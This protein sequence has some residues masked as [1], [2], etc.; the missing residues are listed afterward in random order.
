MFEK[1]KRDAIRLEKLNPLWAI[2]GIG[3]LIL[4]IVMAFGAW[5]WATGTNAHLINVPGKMLVTIPRPDT[6]AGDILCI[7]NADGSGLKQ[8]D[9]GLSQH[10]FAA[11]SPNGDQIA[12]TGLKDNATFPR[13][14]IMNADSSNVHRLTEDTALNVENAP[15]WSPDAR[16]IAYENYDVKTS[17]YTIRTIQNDGSNP[18][19]LVPGKHPVWSPDGQWIAYK[20]IQNGTELYVMKPDGSGAHP[21][22]NAP[23]KEDITWSPDSK[24]LAFIMVE[25][26]G[27][28]SIATVHLDGTNLRQLIK[29]SG[30]LSKPHWSPDGLRIAF[31]WDQDAQHYSPKVMLVSGG[32]PANLLSNANQVRLLDWGK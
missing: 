5:I 22:T 17:Q 6:T 1:R 24:Q 30:N 27:P 7:V 14:Y 28:A 19:V 29:E 9:D 25:P 4:F 20:S 2:P 31:E 10:L 3:L 26:S 15:S 8:L 32:D 18:Q 16:I 23:L 13:I 12:F 11:W 21:V